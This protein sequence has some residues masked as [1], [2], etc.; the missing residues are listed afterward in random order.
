MVRRAEKF[1]DTITTTGAM[2]PDQKFSF[3]YDFRNG[4][5][6]VDGLLNDEKYY[7][8]EFGVVA[9]DEVDFHAEAHQRV[10]D[11]IKKS[12]KKN[13][14]GFD[15]VIK[16]Y[17]SGAREAARSGSSTASSSASSTRGS[18]GGT[19]TSSS[20]SSGSGSGSSSSS[21]SSDG[22]AA[23]A[24]KT[25]QRNT[26][27]ALLKVMKQAGKDVD[28]ALD[29][30][31]RAL[32][33]AQR[34]ALKERKKRLE[35]HA[36]RSAKTGVTVG[37]LVA[38]CG[39]DLAAWAGLVINCCTFA[40]QVYD[41]CRSL[42]KKLRD[43]RKTIAKYQKQ[44]KDHGKQ[45]AKLK[46]LLS[47]AKLAKTVNDV[48]DQ[49][50]RLKGEYFLKRKSVAKLAKKLTQTLDKEDLTEQDE[51]KVAGYLETIEEY[52]DSLAAVESFTEISVPQLDRDMEN[53]ENVISALKKFAK[54]AKVAKK[55]AQVATTS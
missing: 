52:A 32:L 13:Q 30:T 22:D 40:K 11:A 3:D 5:G 10:M 7:R 55:L 42:D 29:K 18:G 1:D 44:R 19:T 2:M 53:L 47:S 12:V 41:D 36:A 24:M 31:F 51:A 49:L 35:Q 45:S 15:S 4:S 27:K 28:K 23:R 20:S 37:R 17:R 14:K 38:S 48:R 34:Q 6:D 43:V 54:V 21:S 25:L 16:A 39:L 33:R 50:T 8:L 46:K 26:R 9:P